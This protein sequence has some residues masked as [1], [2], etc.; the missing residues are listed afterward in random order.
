MPYKFQLILRGSRDG[1]A[2]KTFWD[3]CHGYANTVAIL[4]VK[5]TDEILGGYNPLEL[6][7]DRFFGISKWMETKNNFIFSLKNGNIHNSILSRVKN[8]ANA[9]Y[10][11]TDRN[12]Y[13]LCFGDDDLIM[14]SDNYCQC[15]NKSY[16]EPIRTTDEKFSI[17]DYEIFQIIKK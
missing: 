7:T 3:I 4:K 16:E 12:R 14:Q 1:F 9:L 13:G 10:Y 6:N 17:I 5:G 11:Y 2:P 15:K 8:P